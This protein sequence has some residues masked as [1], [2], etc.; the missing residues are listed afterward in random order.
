MIGSALLWP[1]MNPTASSFAAA[2]VDAPEAADVPVLEVPAETSKALVFAIPEN[3]C[4]SKA[5]EA[6]AARWAV[7]V[8]VGLA[9]AAY[10]SSP[11][12]L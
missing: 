8:V 6:A 4:T 3:S 12:E 1:A 2:T 5:I 10:H 9:F 7:T 11:S